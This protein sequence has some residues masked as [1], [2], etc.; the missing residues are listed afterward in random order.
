MDA[1]AATEEALKQV[2]AA[3]PDTAADAF[4]ALR[5]A[6]G[7]A[8][9]RRW[10]AKADVLQFLAKLYEQKRL[11]RRQVASFADVL[12]RQPGWMA[13]LDS[14][15]QSWPAELAEVANAINPDE[16]E[17]PPETA[18]QP[19]EVEEAEGAEAAEPA[20][21]AEA[22]R[23]RSMVDTMSMLDDA[24]KRLAEANYSFAVLTGSGLEEDDLFAAFEV[25]RRAVCRVTQD[26]CID[27]QLLESITPKDQILKFLLD[28]YERKRLNR[29]RAEALLVLLMHLD[30]WRAAAEETYPEETKQ[31]RGVSLVPDAK[32]AEAHAAEEEEPAL[33]E[34]DRCSTEAVEE[35]PQFEELVTAAKRRGALGVLLVR[36]LAAHNLINA[37]WFSLS[38]PYAKVTVDKE[39]KC[40]SVVDDC[41]DPR[42]DEDLWNFDVAAE[43]SLV[44][45]EVWDKDSLQDD[46]L[47]SLA[48]PISCAPRSKSRLRFALDQVQH[49]ELEVEIAFLRC[50][51]E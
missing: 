34:L 35:E 14:V 23:R 10:E 5:R 19:G 7:S 22:P 3:S 42:W 32:E 40:T 12:L 1:D 11:Y 18:E 6:R 43:S 4:T 50:P 44:R 9:L 31:F 25:F 51:D 26:S 47:G 8:A 45:F 46:P 41:L 15:R 30:G 48:M 28:V 33:D 24:L 39:S 36:V 29:K 13:A 2:C 49:G 21:G 20:P 27:T 37:D 17:E 16:L 38:D